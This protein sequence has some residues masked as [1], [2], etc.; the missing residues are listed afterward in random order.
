MSGK[1]I[2]FGI[3][4]GFIAASAVLFVLLHMQ[5]NPP[6][7][8][9][10]QIASPSASSPRPTK[11]PPRETAREQFL[12]THDADGD[13]AWDEVLVGEHGTFR[14][15]PQPRGVVR[16]VIPVMGEKQIAVF[17]GDPLGKKGG[18]TVVSIDL[19][20]GRE[21]LISGSTPLVSPRN[22][23]AAPRGNVIAFFLDNLR[24]RFTELWTVN[25]EN[26]E[27]QV[28]VERLGQN[29]RGPF[30]DPA[31]GFLL[32]DGNRLVRGSPHRTGVDLI[33]LSRDWRDLLPGRTIIPSPTGEQVIAVV[34]RI[35]TG[36]ERETLI[37][38]WELPEGYERDILTLRET[39]VTFLGWTSS[40]A[41]L[42]AARGDG[43]TLWEL[44]RGS[45]VP[46][47]MAG[48][49]RSFALSSDGTRLAHLV[50]ADGRPALVVL[51]TASWTEVSR[52]R[53]PSAERTPASSA[54]PKMTVPSEYVL[55]QYLRTGDSA[56]A[57]NAGARNSEG[58]APEDVVRYVTEHIR[59][60]TSAPPPEFVMA[61]RVWFTSVPGAVFVDY[62]VGT[63]LWRRLVQVDA[64]GGRPSA[65]RV[66]GI[67]TPAN[68]EWVLA[69]GE[70]LA[71]PRPVL[72]VEYE[73]E[74]E[75]W[76][77]KEVTEDV[78]P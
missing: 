72:L 48:D 5:G 78:H 2:L 41:L 1:G 66:V 55:Q 38:M 10:H 36:G 61:E 23:F 24:S 19:V 53:I 6:A 4:S 14:S 71:D 47:S 11:T 54:T 63:I 8:E 34:G 62:R 12:L 65:H 74:I 76:V 30:W 39:D 58:V 33:P 32:L 20:S 59:E 25:P 3:L 31:G 35:H 22:I 15:V 77:R 57:L 28:A 16:T 46:H 44:R 75:Q 49:A 45:Q 9:G 42:L 67:F 18:V 29:T 17:V 7:S 43:V 56:P 69:Q 52:L 51:D 68:G 60:I 26:G 64:P 21:T 50:D 13:G 37:R 40:G 70:T 73:P 27:K